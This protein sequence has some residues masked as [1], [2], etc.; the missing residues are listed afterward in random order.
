M[1]GF[2]FLAFVIMTICCWGVY[3]P[4]LHH[5]QAGMG[6]GGQLSLLRPIICVGVAY[7]VIAVMF[8][9]FMLFAH[10]EKGQ[11]SFSGFVW[12]FGAGAVGALGAIG[13][14]LS[15][16]FGGLA[17]YVM[18]LVFGFAPV[19]NTIVSMVMGRTM[20]EASLPFFIGVLIVAVGAAGVLVFK[21]APAKKVESHTAIPSVT[22]VSWQDS[23][24][25]QDEASRAET[26]GEHAT[27]ESAQEVQ[28]KQ[29]KPATAETS[30]SSKPESKPERNIVMIVICVAMT[31]LCWGAYGPILHKGQMK[32]A[33][34]RLRPFLCVG[35]AYFALAVILPWM[36]LNSYPE[37]GGWPFVGTSWAL[38]A[39]AAGAIGALGIIY[40]F[41]FG[42]RP[43]FVMPLVFGG[44]PVIN[45]F[46]QTLEKGIGDVPQAFYL[47][48][49]LVI[50][51][52]VTVLICAP[53][54]HVKPA[55]VEP[56]SP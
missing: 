26:T 36:Y 29:D 17:V 8:P 33:G 53:R 28:K 25:E 22:Q 24:T 55:V 40:A 56:A 10:G 50:L 48:L 45:T 23:G 1:K 54:G 32:M 44:A 39:G 2:G 5:G 27:E 49:A 41:N 6:E 47:S 51:G 34:S 3:G 43:I 16:K 15:F 11:W 12:S 14:A 30:V 52:A 7:F 31:A 19:V 9:L 35:I 42:G 4:V 37:P 46:S 21:P 20:K 18:P 13:I 38:A